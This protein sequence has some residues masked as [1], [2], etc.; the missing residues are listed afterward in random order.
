[1]HVKLITLKQIQLWVV[2][3]GFNNARRQG[4]YDSYLAN[5]TQT[6]HQINT[7]NK[8]LATQTEGYNLRQSNLEKD[9]NARNRAAYDAA[10]QNLF[11]SV[12]NVGR[13]SNQVRAN[14]ESQA[15]I[16]EAFPEVYK[17]LMD[18]VMERLNK[19]RNGSN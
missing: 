16:A 12:G 7:T 8:Q 17:Y 6:G 5:M 19:S 1:M 10:V 9:I 13:A 2:V 4:A 14:R 11:T 3:T 15:Y 18:D